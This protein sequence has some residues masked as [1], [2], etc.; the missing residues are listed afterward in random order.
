MEEFVAYPSQTKI[1]VLVLGC[2]GFVAL[3]VWFTG[4]LVPPPGTDR[5]S[6]EV[7]VLVGWVTILLFGGA[8][9]VWLKRLFERR[10]QLRISP[11]GVKAARWSDTTIPWSEI[12]DV[13]TWTGHGQTVIVLHLEDPSRF[14]GRRGLAAATAAANHSF[15][16]GDI[17][18]SLAGTD[19][20]AIDALSAIEQFRA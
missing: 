8:G 9:V 16:G 15:T 18:I 7:V 1:V 5:Y 20:T 11:L 10:V 12:T 4:L 14:P 6:T 3:G 13:T 2:V 17:S 19:R